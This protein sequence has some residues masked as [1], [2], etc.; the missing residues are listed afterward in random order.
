[1]AASVAADTIEIAQNYNDGNFLR[2]WAGAAAL[3]GSAARTLAC[4]RLLGAETSLASICQQG[5]YG[6][7]KLSEIGVEKVGSH[8]GDIGI[9]SDLQKYQLQLNRYFYWLENRNTPFESMGRCNGG[10]LRNPLTDVCTVGDFDWPP[11]L[12]FLVKWDP[13]KGCI[14]D[15]PCS[16]FNH[17]TLEGLNQDAK[18]M[19][20]RERRLLKEQAEAFRAALVQESLA[21]LRE[22]EVAKYPSSLFTVSPSL[23][24]IAPFAVSFDGSSSSPGASP[25]SSYTWDFG[26]GTRG[27]QIKT[28]HTYEIAGT[29]AVDRKSTRL[30]SSHT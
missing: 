24:G 15:Y 18:A 21:R 7:F 4:T 25:I 17:L 20:A 5:V 14:L 27:A 16:P 3:F 28:A 2:A 12:G 6:V 13:L 30:N 19:A 9:Q 22:T 26:D 10:W 29:Y 1:M 8:S 23:S 11:P